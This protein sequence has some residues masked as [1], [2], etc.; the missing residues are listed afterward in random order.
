[1]ING[2][3]YVDLGLSVKW[4]TCNMGASKSE[5]LGDYY[6]WSSLEPNVGGHWLYDNP[7]SEISGT[8]YD[9]AHKDWGGTW[10]MPTR[11]EMQ[12]LID[13]CTWEWTSLNGM[14]GYKIISSN[15]NYIFLPAASCIHTD[16]HVGA[17]GYYWTADR[18]SG[19]NAYNAWGL[20][21]TDNAKYITGWNI[22]NLFSVRPVSN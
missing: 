21:F 17:E 1:M 7:V 22:P 3:E 8:D 5:G 10:R 19:N 11:D 6:S 2:H 20:R 18:C 4:A 16:A 15:G 13:K 9:V 14:N 12:E